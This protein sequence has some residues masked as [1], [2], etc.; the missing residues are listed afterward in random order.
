M[1]S[2]TQDQIIL[3]T[4]ASS[5][6][7]MATAQLLSDLGATIIASGRNQSRLDEL[8]KKC[9]AEKRLIPALRDL[10]ENADDLSAWVRSLAKEYGK[11]TGLVCCAG[12]TE[13]MPLQLFDMDA[14][15]RIFNINYFAPMLLAKGFTDRRANV[16]SGASIVFIASMAAVAPIMGL[17]GYAGSKGALVSSARGLSQETAK[18]GVRVNCITPGLIS[19]PMT[20]NLPSSASD[21]LIEEAKRTA[22]GPGYPRDVA[23]LIAFLMSDC[24][25]WITGQNFI[26]DGGRD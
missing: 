1:I 8:T 12:I 23:Q 19:T 18:T 4:G 21:W 20:N 13:T 24:S 10:T 9:T 11:L 6:L 22:L 25:R 17:I 7:G 2:F 15:Q 14:T 26:I 16:G 3:V 5:G